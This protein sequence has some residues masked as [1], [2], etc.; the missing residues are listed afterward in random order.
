VGRVIEGASGP[1]LWAIYPTREINPSFP[2][3]CKLMYFTSSHLPAI[4]TGGRNVGLP[5]RAVKNKLYGNDDYYYTKEEVDAKDNE[6]I[7]V[8]ES[9]QDKIEDLDTIR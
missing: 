2:S 4:E 8:F 3:D 9:K 1:N 6:I 7:V 5:V